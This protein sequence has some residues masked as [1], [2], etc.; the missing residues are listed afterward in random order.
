MRQLT[1]DHTWTPRKALEEQVAK[2]DLRAW[3]LKEDAPFKAIPPTK[4]E[5]WPAA[6]LHVLKSQLRQLIA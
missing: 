4:A 5:R 6:P 2:E 3:A 1:H